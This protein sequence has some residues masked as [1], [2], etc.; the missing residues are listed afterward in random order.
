MAGGSIAVLDVGKTLSKL[1]LWKADGAL[2][3]RRTRRNERVIHQ[4]WAVLDTTGIENWLADTLRDFAGLSEIAAIVPVGHGAAVALLRDGRLVAPPLDYEQPLPEGDYDSQRDGFGATGSPPLPGGLNIGAQLHALEAHDPSLLKGA[5]ILPWAQYW[6]WLLCGI[7]A[8]EV[9]SL[10]CHSDLWRPLANAPSALAVRRGWA[11]R[12]A[13]LRPASDVLG[14]LTP[15]WAARTGLP[16]SVRVYCGLHDSNAALLAARGFAEIAEREATVLSTGTWF[17][18]MRSPARDAAVM[19][20]PAARD[21]LIN[22]DVRGRPIPSARWMGGR[23][24]EILMG[25]DTRDGDL[26]AGRGIDALPRVLAE[27][28]MLLPGFA[29]GTG[30][31]PAG[32]GRW[33]DGEPADPA[34][35]RAAVH[36]YLA[37]MTDVSLG[38]IGTRERLLVE[39]RFAEAGLF[40]RALAALRPDL[41]IYAANSH[42]DVSYGAR[43]LLQPDLAPLSALTRVAPLD[44]D[45][46]EYR[47][48]WSRE[49]ER[50]GRTA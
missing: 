40:V 24:A 37:L 11:A 46:V 17:V 3:E 25:I 1:T 26:A 21:C 9:T 32:E 16:A 6:A 35:R 30:P 2:I 19:P 45:L 10:G 38:L 36:L 42:N 18:A 43:R 28:H 20:L 5:T 49:A 8:S 15:A 22:V 27:G 13:P 4:G 12:L 50:A 14:T 47:A 23:E 44:H 33:L 29:P 7:A 39:G 48:R 31:F 41:S 34:L